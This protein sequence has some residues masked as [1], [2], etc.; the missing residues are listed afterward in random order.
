M[1]TL[2]LSALEPLL[3]V[4]AFALGLTLAFATGGSRFC[5]YGALTEAARRQSSPRLQGW[6]AAIAVAVAGTALLQAWGLIDTTNSLYTSPRLPWFAHLAGGMIF[7]IGMV[8]AEGCGLRNLTKAGGGDLDAALA[9]L[10]TGLAAFMTMKGILALPR[11]WWIE[12][13]ALQL[14]SAQ[15]LGEVLAQANLPR[16]LAPAASMAALT[17]ALHLRHRTVVLSPDALLRGA[18]VGALV[19]VGWLLSGALGHL[20][21]HP[22]TLE[23]VYLRTGSGRMESLSFVG[24]LA[25]GLDWLLWGSD[26]SRVL[27]IGTLVALGVVV[28]AAL[29]GKR[30][31]MV[32]AASRRRTLQH[33]VGGLLMGIGGV[34]GLG[35]SVGQG[36]TGMSTLSL[37]SFL[38]VGGIVA[39]ALFVLRREPDSGCKA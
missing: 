39:G 5:I 22:E 35:C 8:Y 26:D 31:T 12:P 19:V 13:V 14:P 36:I 30:Q 4:L 6:L 18:A 25:Q 15:T 33:L 34:L 27:T 17:A 2:P 21:E 37:G 3:L 29:G 20:P 32:P 10:T 38:T 7:G 28:G 9:L 1:N 23:E 16:W 24:P 11:T